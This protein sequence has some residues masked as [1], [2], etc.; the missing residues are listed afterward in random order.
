M[1]TVCN[2]II[3]IIKIFL[4]HNKF[5][6]FLYEIILFPLSFENCNTWM[7]LKD[8]VATGCTLQNYIVK[9]KYTQNK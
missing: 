7:H 2:S 9:K 4:Q 3:L 5:Q 1:Q 8:L 6:V